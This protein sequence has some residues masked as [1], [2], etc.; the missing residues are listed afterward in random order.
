MSESHFIIK[1]SKCNTVIGQC[2]CMAQNKEIRYEVCE[3]CSGLKGH[4]VDVP[5][6]KD[7]VKAALG[8]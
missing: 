5:K 1:C 2:R 4:S 7:R 8:L 6:F 3:A